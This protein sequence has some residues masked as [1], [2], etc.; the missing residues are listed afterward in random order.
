MHS[1]IFY[2]T[3]LS[4]HMAYLARALAVRGNDVTYVS[5]LKVSADR[6]K[7][8]WKISDT[9]G[10]RLVELPHDRS[11]ASIP[12]QFPHDAFHLTQGICRNGQVQL[13][14]PTLRQHH[15]RWGAMMETVDD[16]GF[17]GSLKRLDYMWRLRWGR[18]RPD[19][20]LAT[21]ERMPAWLA[22]RGFPAARIFPFTYFL[23]PAAEHAGARHRRVPGTPV[24]GFVGQMIQLKR[25]DL[26]IDALAQLEREDFRL[27]LIGTGPLE[28]SLRTRAIEALGQRRVDWRG[29]CEIDEARAAMASLDLLVLPSRH[30]GWG[31]VVSEALLAGTPAIC[32]DACGASE[33]VHASGL[34]GVFRKNNIDS[35]CEVLRRA[36][37]DVPRTRA[38][39]PHIAAWANSSFSIQAGAKYLEALAAHLY[40]GAPR[41]LPPWR[42]CRPDFE[43]SVEAT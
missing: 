26:L 11:A 31:A 32:S 15:L 36:L 38:L 22:A 43:W 8:G 41:P 20:I 30:D 23:E 25:V 16:E 18:L 2:Q 7:M 35:L 1:F 13:I 21:G 37:D 17:R 12:R 27:Q 5:A 4:P 40:G 29:R 28:S 19:F 33:A 6:A 3:G 24:I 34:G 39:R 42:A 10:V 9:A 14:L